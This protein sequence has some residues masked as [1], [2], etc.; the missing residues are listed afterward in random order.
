MSKQITLNFN[1]EVKNLF[2]KHNI[3][4]HDGLGYLMCLYYSISPTYI[5]KELERKILSTSIVTKDYEHDSIK[6]NISLFEETETGFEWISDW[7]DLFKSVNPERRGT[8]ADVLRRMKKFFVNN[9]SIRK[10]EIFEAT[11]IYLLSISSP[12]YCKKSHKFIYE[13][14]GSSM[15]GDYVE[16]LLERKGDTTFNDDVI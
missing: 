13:I 6:W 3:S 4:V 7:M 14:D 8:K 1:S 2:I 11:K 15:L 5:P 10:D 12:Q 16:Q 9:P